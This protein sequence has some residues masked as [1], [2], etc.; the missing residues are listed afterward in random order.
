MMSPSAVGERI[1]E[2]LGRRRAPAPVEQAA[3]VRRRTLNEIGLET[4]TD[5]ASTIHDYLGVYERNLGHLRDREFLL[6]EIGVH[7]GAAP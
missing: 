3:P 2:R 4:G 7:Q 1:R 6:V 5:K